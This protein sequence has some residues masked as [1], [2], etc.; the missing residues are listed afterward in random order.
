SEFKLKKCL[1][2]KWFV[3][4]QWSDCPVE[5][6][7]AVGFI[8]RYYELGNDRHIIK[9]SIRDLEEPFIEDD[10][11]SFLE[12]DS[13]ELEVQQKIVANYIRKTQPSI[14]IDEEIILHWW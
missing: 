14:G 9:T 4:A 2:K 12:D 5:V 8:W 3:D 11:D 10:V 7:E 6:R 1:T 13:K